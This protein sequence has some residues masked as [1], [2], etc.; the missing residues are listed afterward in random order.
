M[1]MDTLKKQDDFDLKTMEVPYFVCKMTR[2]EA[3]SGATSCMVTTQD[4][5]QAYAEQFFEVLRD[6]TATCE[7][8]P[9]GY[10]LATC[11]WMQPSASEDI[12]RSRLSV[13]TRPRPRIVCT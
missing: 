5:N 12:T 13:Q 6:I 9:R 10:R 7:L 3:K 2:P 4:D 8:D 1:I 11:Y